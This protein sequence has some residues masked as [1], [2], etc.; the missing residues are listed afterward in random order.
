MKLT[1]LMGSSGRPVAQSITVWTPTKVA[2]I[3]SGLLR[4]AWS[5]T[6]PGLVIFLDKSKTCNVN[7]VH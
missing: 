7:Y 5:K 3:V 1:V 2:G 6:K 4:S